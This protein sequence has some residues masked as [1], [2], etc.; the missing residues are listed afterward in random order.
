MVKKKAGDYKEESRESFNKQT[1]KYDSS[2][3]G[4]HGK[5]LHDNVISKLNHI[6]FKSLLDVGCGTGNL[7]SH[8]SSKFDAK[9]A[10]VDISQDMLEIAREK[11]DE[12]ADLRVSDAENLPFDDE[13]FEV[14][15]CTDSFHHYP[16]PGNVLLEFK[17]VLKPE[18]C[19]IIADLSVP[20]PFRQLGNLLI[21]FTKDGDVRIY[22]ES[23]I[24]KLLVNTGFKGF[25][26]EQI[27]MSTFIV[28]AFK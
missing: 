5:K 12:K 28:T 4:K 17:R 3:Y 14:V 16:H 10:G 23:E 9:I 21:P 22:S 20:Q 1:E 19:I 11:L 26:W 13:S 15:T 7:L 6:S 25:K 24:H 8:I 27:S 18:G 2:Y